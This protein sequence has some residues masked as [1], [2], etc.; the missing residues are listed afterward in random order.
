MTDGTR[1]ELLDH[2]AKAIGSLPT[3]HPAL[4]AVDG[5][6]ASGKTTLAD[7]LAVVL[8]AQGRQVIRAG[9]DDFLH[10]QAD[11]Y[12][13]GKYSAEACYQDSFDFDAIR[14][15]LLDPLGPG[16]DRK[17]R[18]GFRDRLTDELL[19]PPVVTAD[20]DAVLLFDGVFLMRPELNDRW[21]LR[22]LVLAD[23]AETLARSLIRDRLVHSSPGEIERRFH[24]RYGP[25]QDAYFATV[26]P[27]ELADVVVHNNN[28][29]QP[30]WNP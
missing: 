5:R 10:P 13:R 11:R 8:R 18:P 3:A 27:T 26:R 2:L 21:H 12:R 30:R 7:E 6:P 4:V 9:I 25:S 17:C 23:F 24:G 1:D 19:H 16:G 15:L 20:D 28:P 14:R 22:I 29:H